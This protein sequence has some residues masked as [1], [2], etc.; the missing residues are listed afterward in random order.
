MELKLIFEIGFLNAWIYMSVFIIQMLIVMFASESIRQRSHAP[1]DIKRSWLE[2]YAGILANV[3]WFIALAYS[4]FLPLKTSTLWFYIGSLVFF[5][6][7]I[8]LIL[9]TINFMRTPA[10]QVITKGIY[11]ITRHP[12]YVATFLICTGSGIASGSLVF[13]CLSIILTYCLH[14]EALVEEKYCLDTYGQAYQQY[15]DRVPRWM[16]IPKKI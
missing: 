13:M 1:S 5:I 10:N 9:G 6:G 7:L 12:M 16:G 4:V 3:V 2:K 14:K 11:A 15:L 8:Y